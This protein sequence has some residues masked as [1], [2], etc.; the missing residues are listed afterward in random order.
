VPP[1]EFN[2]LYSSKPLERSESHTSC[3]LK[4]ELESLI[5]FCHKGV[6]TD[7]C[8]S[9][10]LINARS[11]VGKLHSLRILSTTVNP[12]FICVTETWLTHTVCDSAIALPGYVAH[13]AD[14]PFKAGGGCL[15]YCRDDLRVSIMEDL[16]D[17]S[18]LEYLCVKTTNS[19][20]ALFLGCIYLPPKTRNST[21]HISN[22]FAAASAS[23][24]SQHVI[25]GDFNL[26]NVTWNCPN[27]P[28]G[29]SAFSSQLFHDGWVQNISQPTRGDNILDLVFTKGDLVTTS[30]V[31]PRFPESDHNVVVCNI[32]GIRPLPPTAL[33]THHKLTPFI[34]QT[35]SSLI[36]LTDWSKFFLS[37]DA[38]TSANLLYD[39]LLP[40][41]HSVSPPQKILSRFEPNGCKATL[42]LLRSLRK[43]KREYNKTRC[44]GILL[45]INRIASRIQSMRFR[46]EIQQE[47]NVLSQPADP[48][49]L[50]KL[51]R[52]RKPT[53]PYC[54]T[55]L[56]L[57]D[58]TLCN[59]PAT[60]CE[61]LNMFF[62]RCY[63]EAT[64]STTP[65]AT[66]L[67][68]RCPV[69][70]DI[71]ARSLDTISI[72][73]SD[74]S[75]QVRCI[76]PSSIPGPDGIPA[77]VLTK[78]GPDLPLLLYQLF[79]TSLACGAVPLQWKLSV[80]TPRYKSGPRTSA[81]SYRGIH[82]TSL[83]LRILERIIKPHITTHLL[84]RNLISNRQYGFISR[85]STSA[86]QT[87][88]FEM[89]SD[90]YEEGLAV[91]LIYLDIS[92]AFDRV[93]HDAI[94]RHLSNAGIAG[95][96]LQWFK[97]YLTGRN[98]I[99][100]VFD[101]SSSS[102]PIT[103]GV[104]QG[105]VL[106]PIL[107]L[108]Y[109][110]DALLHVTTGDPF[111]F[112][113]DVKIAY[114]FR[115][116]DLSSTLP[117]IQRDLDALSAWSSHS[118]LSFSP[119][120]CLVL[121]FRC[122][123]DIPSLKVGNSQIRVSPTVCDLGLR[124]SNLFNFSQQAHYQIAKAR[125]IS[126]YILHSFHLP[127]VKLA[128]FKQRVRPILEY[129]PMLFPHYTESDRHSI[130]S[131]QRMF[132]RILMPAG[133]SSNYRSRCEHFKIDPLW[134]RRLKLNL[135]FLHRL[136]N[137]Q[138]HTTNTFLH[139][140]T[141]TRYTRNSEAKITCKLSRS[142]FKHNSF[143]PFYSRIWN[144]LPPDLRMLTNHISFRKSLN[145]FLSLQTVAP[146]FR[147]QLSDDV[148][149]EYGPRHV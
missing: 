82:H 147:T 15:I 4:E 89:I 54:I 36:R 9:I 64:K 65:A 19:N 78:C 42:N 28:S 33:V 29:I 43:A 80:I 27:G 119:D 139:L 97:S 35:V 73:L 96:L 98:Q 26:P 12:S 8:I 41:L 115:P 76:R 79:C 32:K 55:S 49:L 144:R 128:L 95:P 10:I 127:A 106:G 69:T 112:A 92:K 52:L 39:T 59:S 47:E 11:L 46:H 24:Y 123:V 5:D 116:K 53:D 20:P 93:P 16:P 83:L 131:V 136:V 121:T 125:R 74:V 120:K 133:L 130:E 70:P 100:K 72:N 40:L 135:V 87:D 37:K 34:L 51:I 44:F 141:P 71:N 1:V 88:F 122:P 143:V 45:S 142:A 7:A 84:S 94:L 90:A 48:R 111:L 63:S 149:C 140:S 2:N 22:F 146:L 138:V 77:S 105:S 23:P 108:L 56:Q 62:A 18:P 81:N 134:M 117:S 129:C 104:I 148:L 137:A 68:P 66:L 30:S 110:N 21:S 103:S 86:C 57:D 91:I 58:G 85:R 31:G 3:N 132:T 107:F 25:V 109:I 114:K 126:F 145:Q 67:N 17:S 113:D 13:R 60:M 118:G 50:S 99:T 75:K 38:Q 102:A 124:Y 101:C 61:F 6:S 14:R